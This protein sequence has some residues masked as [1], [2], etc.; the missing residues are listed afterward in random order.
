M[1]AGPYSRTNAQRPMYVDEIRC[2]WTGHNADALGVYV[3]KVNTTEL[4][5]ADLAS[6]AG[7]RQ[8][9]RGYSWDDVIGDLPPAGRNFISRWCSDHDFPYDDTETIG[10]LLMRV[11]NAGLFA[12]GNTA[13]TT[14][15]QALNQA[16][17][18]K[19]AGLCQKWGEATPGNTET[20]RQISNRLGPVFW[21]GNDDERVY[22]E[23]F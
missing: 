19:I 3:C 15:Y 13:L 17:R 12:L 4:K 7:V 5:H 22:V 9:P 21:P 11:V 6:R 2:N 8:M 18:D 1:V 23:E 10:Q 16:Q 14:Q 20:V